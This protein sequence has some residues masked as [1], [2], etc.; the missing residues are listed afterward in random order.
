MEEWLKT[1]SYQGK[2]KN[3][4]P[5]NRE[6][7]PKKPYLFRF[8]AAF[9]VWYH[10]RKRHANAVERRK[11]MTPDANRSCP[12]LVMTLLEERFYPL[13]R[14]RPVVCRFW[15]MRA[16]KGRAGVEIPVTYAIGME[17]MTER[18]LYCVGRDE[19]EA[20]ALFG[21]IVEGRLSPLH[22]GDVVEDFHWEQGQKGKDTGEILK[23]TLQTNQ[24]MV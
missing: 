15:R 17:G 6:E 7:I 14:T 21:R 13:T 22:L 2:L 12:C 3:D 8:S 10:E 4:R 23:K 1:L 16:V 18:Y 19:G 9:R 20:Y 11:L 5:W 24:N